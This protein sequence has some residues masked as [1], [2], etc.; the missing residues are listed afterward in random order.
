MQWGGWCWKKERPFCLRLPVFADKSALE[1]S[2][3]WSINRLTERTF[4]AE[5]SNIIPGG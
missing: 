5:C 1:V 3:L 2:Q 4:D